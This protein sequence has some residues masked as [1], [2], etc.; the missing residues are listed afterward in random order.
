MYNLDSAILIMQTIHNYPYFYF[1]RYLKEKNYLASIARH[2]A[3]RSSRQVLE[4][5]ARIARMGNKGKVPNMARGLSRAEENILW[6]S[7]QLGCNSS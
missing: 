3:F 4:G 1:F 5:K 6:E 7:G 2:D